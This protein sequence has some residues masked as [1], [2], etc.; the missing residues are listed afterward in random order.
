M[1]I[2]LSLSLFTLAMAWN[3]SYL[4]MELPEGWGCELVQGTWICQST[5]APD[6]KESVLL[7]IATNPTDFDS[8]DNYV[9]YLKKSRDLK[10]DEGNPY[11]S[12]VTYSRK[13]NINGHEW[14]DSLQH[15]SEL[16]GFWT[17]YLATVYAT[18]KNKLAIL[19]TYVV[20][21]E[22]YSAISA[23]FERMLA[24]LKPNANFDLNVLS[25]QGDLKFPTEIQGPGAT[26]QDILRD[27]LNVRKGPLA[28]SG[29][30]K[31]TTLLLAFILVAAVVFVFLRQKKKAS[32]KDRS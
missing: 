12:T 16:P 26:Q 8:L 11:T 29:S 30:K 20:S 1:L 21:D 17:R 3:N 23:S 27:R 4:S 19:V 24:T 10:D 18:E 2:Q 5:L 6:R 15:H 9:E 7:S 28:V 32:S 22:R 25:K 14:V 31:T 13:R